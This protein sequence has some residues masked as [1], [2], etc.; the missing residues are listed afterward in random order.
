MN[1]LICDDIKNDADRLAGLLAESGF[2]MQATV[3]TCPRQTFNH[4]RFCTTVD[5]CFLDIVMPS[6]SGIELAKKLREINYAGE[7]VFLTTSNEFAHQSYRVKAFD[8]LL[9]PPT[10]ESVKAVM[11]SLN[12]MR[13]NAD[14]SGL[15]VKMQGVA[16]FIPF[17][18]I[19]HVEVIKHNV[20]IKLLD[21]S[22][23]KVHTVFGEIAEQLLQDSRFARCHRSYIV[24]LNEIMSIENTEVIMKNYAKIPI[25]RGYLQV[26]EK[27]MKQMFR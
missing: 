8:Y 22:V 12:K 5:V 9:K 10:L 7:I 19:S 26:K 14:N 1:I 15:S 11:E 13:E 3:F 27:M 17:R 25:S 18:N 2:E 20:F 23:I 6:M 16:R 21:K 24:N 4:I